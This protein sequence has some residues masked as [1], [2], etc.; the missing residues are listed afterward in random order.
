MA[1]AIVPVFLAFRAADRRLRAAPRCALVIGVLFMAASVWLCFLGMLPTRIG[2]PVA[3]ATPILVGRRYPV[4]A[5]LLA[6]VG[7]ATD[8][9][10]SGS[11]STSPDYVIGTVVVLLL[12]R[13]A[14]EHRRWAREQFALARTQGAA[15]E[16]ER[17]AQDL[18]DGLGQDMA[19]LL[20]NHAILSRAAARGDDDRVRQ[21]IE[22]NGRLL[23]DADRRMRQTIDG[24]SSMTVAEQL[25]TAVRALTVGGVAPDVPAHVPDL[26]ASVDTTLAWALREAVT[27]VLRHAA[28]S[29]EAI[30]VTST[31]CTGTLT[32]RDDGEGLDPAPRSA[33]PAQG[34]GLVGMRARIGAA[35][36]TLDV[37]RTSHGCT[38]RATLPLALDGL[39]DG[40]R[41][42]R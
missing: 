18:H 8:V 33:L 35:G 15:A 20:L 3:A 5:G 14:S 27:N 2:L 25:E 7:A 21:A 23:R 34:R 11:R 4:V 24:S 22:E 40:A 41:D 42:P 1:R 10:D 39:P 13:A 9:L 37:A 12:A 29:R 31:A 26:P 30:D 36:G 16:R 28:A 6:A 32:V 19:V 38:V 17:I